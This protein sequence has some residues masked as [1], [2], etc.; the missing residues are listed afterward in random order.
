MPLRVFQ[1]YQKSCG[2]EQD[3]LRANSHCGGFHAS[4]TVGVACVGVLT[5]RRR[6]LACLAGQIGQSILPVPTFPVIYG[7]EIVLN[8][9]EI[10]PDCTSR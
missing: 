4:W 8:E 6:R 5:Y 1:C 3:V 2:L 10:C 7:L 9:A